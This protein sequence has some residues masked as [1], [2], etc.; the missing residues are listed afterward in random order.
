M[1]LLF[2]FFVL[3]STGVL[4]VIILMLDLNISDYT[5]LSFGSSL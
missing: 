5:I 2:E 4:P 3:S 1:V